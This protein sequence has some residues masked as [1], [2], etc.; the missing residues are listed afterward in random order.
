MGAGGDKTLK[1]GSIGIVNPGSTVAKPINY[2]KKQPGQYVVLVKGT[3]NILLGLKTKI[4]IVSFRIDE[5][6][7]FKDLK[8]DRASDGFKVGP[9]MNYGDKIIIY[10]H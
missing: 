4:G 10:V 2:Y 3:T 5:N 9:L 7:Q 8:T 1:A 6:G